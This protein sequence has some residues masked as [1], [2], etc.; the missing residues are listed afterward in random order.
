MVVNLLNSHYYAIIV[1][2]LRLI[3]P[4]RKQVSVILLILYIALTPSLTANE[5]NLSLDS[6]DGQQIEDTTEDIVEI[7]S[8]KEVAINGELQRIC[9]CES[10]WN[11]K[12]EPK[13][14]APDGSPLQN[15]NYRNGTLH[16]TDWGACQINDLYWG[17]KAKELGLDYK[18]SKNDNYKLATYIYEQGGSTPWNW[19]KK[20]WGE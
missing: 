3:K 15:K 13:Q 4:K 16:S 2:K 14:F 8:E 7:K 18:H 19:S 9:A 5:N 10:T 20:C 6:F 12:S 11:P 17:E 1:I